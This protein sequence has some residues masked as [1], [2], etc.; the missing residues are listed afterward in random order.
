[1]YNYLKYLK[2]DFNVRAEERANIYFRIWT[3]AMDLLKNFTESISINTSF[4]II[5]IMMLLAV[6]FHIIVYSTYL[7]RS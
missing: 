6:K 3:E 1:M 4:W 7:D 5:E 2:I